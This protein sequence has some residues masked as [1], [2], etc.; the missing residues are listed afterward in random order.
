MLRRTHFDLHRPVIFL[1]RLAQFTDG[2][3][4]V[5]GEGA[6]DMGLQLKPRGSRDSTVSDMLPLQ[7]L[8]NLF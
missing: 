4:E 5:R 2:V 1:G 6:V 7:P 8:S 3:S